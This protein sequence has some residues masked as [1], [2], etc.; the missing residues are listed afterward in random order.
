MSQ[1]LRDLT[2]DNIDN[3]KTV[4]KFDRP[5]AADEVRGC[6]LHLFNRLISEGYYSK[7]Q[8]VAYLLRELPNTH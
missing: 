3:L 4:G 5:A 8:I 1:I 2:D 7:G 6:G